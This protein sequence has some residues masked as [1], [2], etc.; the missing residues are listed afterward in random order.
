MT[1]RLNTKQAFGTANHLQDIFDQS[2]AVLCQDKDHLGKDRLEKDSTRIRTQTR[3]VLAGSLPIHI[4]AVNLQK[5]ALS[6]A[7]Q[8]LAALWKISS[9]AGA[10]TESRGM[11][12]SGS[13]L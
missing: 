7:A 9:P 5:R 2:L 4:D 13:A 1:Q 8:A 6:N 12:F 10:K 11:Q 3:T